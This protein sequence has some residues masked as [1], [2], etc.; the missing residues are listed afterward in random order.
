M[1]DEIYNTAKWQ[2]TNQP[3]LTHQGIAQEG[4]INEGLMIDQ[5]DT[6]DLYQS[7]G[8]QTNQHPA[9]SYVVNV[10]GRPRDDTLDPPP[11]PPPPPMA[12][13]IESHAS[14]NA[15]FDNDFVS[16]IKP[17]NHQGQTPGVNLYFLDPGDH[18]TKR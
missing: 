11:P 15:V 13:R 14:D 7:G 9:E 12:D 3:T 8:Y 16:E 17:N 18:A 1:N 4:A 5:Q 10:N 2:S 6:N